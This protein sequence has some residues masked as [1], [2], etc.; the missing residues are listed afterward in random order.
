M[1]AFPAVTA[2]IIGIFFYN[3]VMTS[4]FLGYGG[5]ILAHLTGNLL[6]RHGIPET[7]LNDDAFAEG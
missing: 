6:E 5:R 4:Y 7:G 2:G 3:F 1:L